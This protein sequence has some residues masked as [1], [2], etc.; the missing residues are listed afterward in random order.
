MSKKGFGAL[1]T[2]KLMVIASLND[3]QRMEMLKDWTPA[4]RALAKY[5]VAPLG[6]KLKLMHSEVAYLRNQLKSKKL[7]LGTATALS[8]ELLNASED[9]GLDLLTGV[10]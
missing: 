4:E 9:P 5:A 2:T 3:R 8:V 1:S 6:S 10:N 7:P